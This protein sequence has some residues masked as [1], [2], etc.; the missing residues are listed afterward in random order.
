MNAAVKQKEVQTEEFR[1]FLFK[2]DVDQIKTQQ[3]GQDS[4]CLHQRYGFIQN[5]PPG[6]NGKYRYQVHG[7]GHAGRR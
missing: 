7:D 2:A 3:N 1:S 5:N 4:G 6:N